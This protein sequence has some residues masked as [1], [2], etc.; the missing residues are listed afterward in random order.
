MTNQQITKQLART[1]AKHESGGTD[2]P[3]SILGKEAAAYLDLSV[4][5]LP[6]RKLSVKE[7][8]A[9]LGLSVS[10]LNKMRLNGTGPPYLKLGRRVL[11]DLRDLEAW[12]SERKRNHTSEQL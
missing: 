5:P 2:L 3:S 12:A 9:Y 6:S 1:A 10:T 4:T 7:A 8:A 11:Y